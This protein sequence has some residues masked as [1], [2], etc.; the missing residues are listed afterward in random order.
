[1]L[2]TYKDTIE[3]ET[4]DLIDKQNYMP[5]FQ[6]LCYPVICISDLTTTHIDS[7]INLLARKYAISLK[8]ILLPKSMHIIAK[9]FNYAEL[10]RLSGHYTIVM[11]GLEPFK[12]ENNK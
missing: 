10:Y 4:D 8:S 3:F 1:M 6:I 7:C 9:R 2:C 5:A 12:A 11:S